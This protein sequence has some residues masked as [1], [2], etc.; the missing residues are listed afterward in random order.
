M[1]DFSKKTYKNILAEQLKQVPEEFDKREKSIIQ[2]ALGPESWYL[3]GFYLDLDNIQK[4][5]HARTAK[6]NSLDLKAEERGI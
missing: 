4:N 5:A 3:E 1:I 6:G 2:T